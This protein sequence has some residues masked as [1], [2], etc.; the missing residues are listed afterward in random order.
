[1][2]SSFE[3]VAVFLVGAPGTG[4]STIAQRLTARL[5]YS[6]FLS[7]QT[8][9]RIAREEPHTPVGREVGARL[10]RNES[11][12]I[13]LYCDVVGRALGGHA[14]TGLVIDGYPRTAGQCR[15]IPSVLS[16]AGLPDAAVI[17]ISLWA[18]AELSIERIANRSVCPECGGDT[19]PTWRC[20]ATNT[21]SRRTDD[22]PDNTLARLA[23]Y[24]ETAPGIAEVFTKSWHYVDVDASGPVDDVV[25]GV[26]RV[27]TEFA[28]RSVLRNVQ[29][30]HESG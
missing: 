22:T 24:R 26:L 29:A 19:T 27:L 18:N 25:A 15:A 23:T 7:G 20:C 14:H 8:L 10:G 21:R 17:G 5:G 1:M 4:K 16:S 3:K 12:P 2:T 13:D 9:R 11:M 30:V 28:P 6:L